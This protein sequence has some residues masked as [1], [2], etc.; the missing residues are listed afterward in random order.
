MPTFKS[1]SF[2]PALPGLTRTPHWRVLFIQLYLGS[3]VRFSSDAV[4]FGGA[5]LGVGSFGGVGFAAGLLAIGVGG[6]RTAC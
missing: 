2:K 1:P 6:K 5:G 4:G 3:K